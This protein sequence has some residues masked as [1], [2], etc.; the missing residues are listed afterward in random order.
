M[1]ADGAIH[2]R[3]GEGRLVAFVVAEAAVAEHVD[4][5]RLVEPLP[6]FGGDLGAEHHRLGVVAVGVEDRRLDQLGDVGG[7]RR[8]ARVARI[9][10]EA[11]LVVD[12]EMH[13]AAGAV[14]AQAGEAEALGDHALSGEGRVAVDQQRQH[15]GSLD[16]VVELILLGAHLAQHHRIDDLEMRRVGGERQVDAVVVEL[17][18]GRSAEMV[19]H[20]AGAFDLVGRDR[21]A[22]ELVE[23]GA[24]RL[25]HHLAEHVETPAMGHS[26]GDLLEAELAAALDDL[27][28][29]RDH[30]LRAVEAE[31]LAAGVFDVEE[32]LEAL[33][34]DQLAEDRPLAFLGELD[35]LARPLDALLDPRLLGRIGNVDELE[36]DRAAI[37]AAQDRQHF[38]HGRVFEAEHV[39]DEDLAVPVALEEAVSGR[40][41][42]LVILLRLEAERIEIGVQMAAHAV[43]ADHHQR[44]HAVAGGAMDRV[45]ALRRFGR[46]GGARAQ[47]V[48]D[49]LLGRRPVAVER[50]G[51]L[52]L[53]H[54]RPVGPPPRGAFRGLADA[55][56]IVAERVEE[57]APAR[58]D[59]VRVLLVLG[60]QRLDIGAVGPVEERGLQQLLVDVLPR[61]VRPPVTCRS[62]RRPMSCR[63][64]PATAKRECP[65]P[66]SPRSCLRRRPCRRR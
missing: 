5:D 3:L 53:G 7:V 27:F 57:L 43:G 35:L 21:A 39:V 12:D 18:V 52:V 2:Q 55:G 42:L 63:A 49:R 56:G 48:A 4:H 20:V 10:G 38:A 40:M 58:L 36:A 31:A 30:R 51:Q 33:G 60:L 54:D 6:V 34:L 28:E 19:L 29:R 62:T 25:A 9:G 64:A 66:S 17:A 46:R 37:G 44:A 47:L 8:R 61:H 11:D 13:R 65:P 45:V 50:V 59:R 16:V 24:V 23:D 26:Q 14:A 32:I 22:L 15:L 1:G 41:Q